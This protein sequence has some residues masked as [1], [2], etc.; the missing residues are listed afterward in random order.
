MNPSEISIKEKAI[1]ALL[2]LP[3]NVGYDD[4]MEQILFLS[5]LDTAL[6]ERDKGEYLSHEEVEARLK[7]KWQ[8]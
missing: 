4:I 8:Q 6:K 1:K 7:R 2:A 5:K 3:N